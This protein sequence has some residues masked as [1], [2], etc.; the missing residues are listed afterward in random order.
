MNS[1][2]QN[3]PGP[4]ADPLRVLLVDN[5]E[6]ITALVN[7]ILSDEGYAVTSLNDTDHASVASAVGRLEPDCILLDSAEGPDFGGSWSEAAYLSRR[8]RPVPS[9]MFTAHASAVA[10]A[11]D[12]ETERAQQADFAAI[13][14]KPFSL[15][16]LL[17]A[18]GTAAGRSQRFT[19]SEAADRRRTDELVGQLRTAG[20]IDIRTSE[21]REWA[22]FVSPHDHRL[23]Q[24][25]W[26]QQQGRYMLGRY[27]D[28]ARLEM[29]GEYFERSAAID[30]ALDATPV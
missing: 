22:T 11:R 16:E 7:A 4:D 24:L 20:A 12:G 26:W 8:D 1:Q 23:Y 6:D 29:I 17:E 3:A 19:H 21:R 9:V 14:P 18:V 15:D 13:V 25:Y 2:L 30:A 10:E 28:S 5:D 27:D